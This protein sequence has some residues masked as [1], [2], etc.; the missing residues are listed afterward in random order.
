LKPLSRLHE[1]SSRHK[2]KVSYDTGWENAQGDVFVL[3]V[4]FTDQNLGWFVG[5]WECGFGL[6][7]KKTGKGVEEYKRIGVVSDIG[8]SAFNDTEDEIIRIV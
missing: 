2:F 1:V 4:R 7:L 3:L 5:H 8:S 6:A